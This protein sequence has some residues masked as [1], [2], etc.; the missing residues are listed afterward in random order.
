MFKDENRHY[1]LRKL[2]VGLASVLIGISFVSG[3][4]HT[5]KADTVKDGS[6][7]AQTVVQTT[8]TG[9]NAVVKGR[10][11]VAEANAE[12]TPEE[13]SQT[14]EAVKKDFGTITQ[15]IRQKAIKASEAA[16]KVQNNTEIGRAHV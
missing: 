11:V 3:N 4:N 16:T 9:S 12:S 5:V 15:D 13:Q 10:D 1:S 6:N 2:S 14:P 8:A 7:G